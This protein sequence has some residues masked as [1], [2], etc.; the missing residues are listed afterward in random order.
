MKNILIILTLLII[1]LQTYSQTVSYND[2]IFIMNNVETEKIDDML[3]K[4]GFVIG[5]VNNSNDCSSFD[6]NYK[7][8]EQKLDNVHVVK[9]L[10]DEHN[11]KVVVYISTNLNNYEIIRKEVVKYGYKKNGEN[12]YGDML[13]F[14]YQKGKYRFQFSKKN[15]QSINEKKNQ[16][17]QYLIILRV[18]KD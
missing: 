14:E 15:V 9:K 3:N 16:L 13:N 4:K 6:W 2:I 5:E 17:T 12:A 10:C 1:S 8:I 7:N 18:Q 11:N